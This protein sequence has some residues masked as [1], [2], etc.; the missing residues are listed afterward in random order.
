MLRSLVGSEMCIRDSFWYSRQNQALGEGGELL[1]DK[2][3]TL[4]AVMDESE[5]MLN[6]LESIG[7]TH[8]KAYSLQM[9]QSRVQALNL[10]NLNESRD[11]NASRSSTARESQRF[12]S[13]SRPSTAPGVR[14]TSTLKPT[15]GASRGSSMMMSKTKRC[16]AFKPKE[17]TPSPGLYDPPQ[18]K[19]GG[20]KSGAYSTSARFPNRKAQ[21]INTYYAKRL[22]PT[23]RRN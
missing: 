21:A 22:E 2:V 16:Q 3:L 23:R 17:V 18:K 15:M 4:L 6:V 7:R 19:W 14:F 13:S 12:V 1:G 10:T 20:G 8:S 5:G 11:M 9:Q